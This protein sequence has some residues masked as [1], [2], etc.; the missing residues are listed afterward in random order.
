M[1][2]WFLSFNR[3]YFIIDFGRPSKH[4]NKQ[5]TEEF[6]KTITII[7]AARTG[8]LPSA[9][10]ARA[11]RTVGVLNTRHNPLHMGGGG[12]EISN[13]AWG[14]KFSVAS[15]IIAHHYHEIYQMPQLITCKLSVTASVCR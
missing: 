10:S 12:A 7:E 2:I 9:V 13:S 15:F 3:A 14:I 8:I 1:Y 5:R 11:W 4:E 6:K